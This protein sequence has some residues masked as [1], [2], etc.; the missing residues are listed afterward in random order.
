[1]QS[2]PLDLLVSII[3]II[4]TDELAE[5]CLVDRTWYKIVRCELY[6]RCRNCT[7]RYGHLYR[8]KQVIDKKLREERH[9]PYTWTKTDLESA[10]NLA[11][12]N[13]VRDEQLKIE[14][15]MLNYG[16]IVDEMER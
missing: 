14:Q 10:N 1:M 7:I 3:E 2:L 8:N 4:P 6:K 5:K 15:F 13:K 16:M 11:Q 12:I 9:D